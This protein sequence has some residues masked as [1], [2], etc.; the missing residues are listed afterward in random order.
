MRSIGFCH[1]TL[2]FEIVRPETHWLSLSETFVSG[3]QGV[4][5]SHG[6][7]EPHHRLGDVRERFMIGQQA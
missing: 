1:A 4:N 7:A 5:K 3:G 6:G 2:S